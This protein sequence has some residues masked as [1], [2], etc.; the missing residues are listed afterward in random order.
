MER[1]KRKIF[2]KDEKTE[3]K[4]MFEKQI[5]LIVIKREK[6]ILWKREVG[7]KYGFYTEKKD[8]SFQT[9]VVLPDLLIVPL[10]GQE[11]GDTRRFP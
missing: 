2:A 6:Y 9:F 8:F 4:R 3:A 10:L 1:E 7:G 5:S 11:L